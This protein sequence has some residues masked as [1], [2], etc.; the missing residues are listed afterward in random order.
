M[1][2]ENWELTLKLTYEALTPADILE[3][4]KEVKEVYEIVNPDTPYRE[5]SIEVAKSVAKARMLSFKQWKALTA[6]VYVNTKPEV[7]YKKF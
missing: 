5:Y 6:F 4:L 2:K 3:L 1:K 7:N